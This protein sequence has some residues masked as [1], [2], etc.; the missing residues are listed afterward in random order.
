[1]EKIRLPIAEGGEV[2]MQET[3]PQQGR[4]HPSASEFLWCKQNVIP[5]IAQPK[6]IP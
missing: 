4:L 3:M 1:V 5:K 6:E 2:K